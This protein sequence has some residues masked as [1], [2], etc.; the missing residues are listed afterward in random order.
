MAAPRESGMKLKTFK[1]IP[2]WVVE[3][4]DEVQFIYLI[5]MRNVITSCD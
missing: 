3:D 4:H 2:V 5:L 1:K